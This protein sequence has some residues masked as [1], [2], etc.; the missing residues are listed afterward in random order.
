MPISKEKWYQEAGIKKPS[1]QIEILRYIGLEGELSKRMAQIKTGSDYSDVSN[2][3][4]SLL[5]RTKMIRIS[6][7]AKA[8]RKDKRYYALTGKGLEAFIDESSSP[9]SSS[10]SFWKAI[11]MLSK[12]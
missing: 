10:E 8:G 11:V 1:L 7:P 5:K 9:S 2:A 3:I 12:P 4:D 6:S